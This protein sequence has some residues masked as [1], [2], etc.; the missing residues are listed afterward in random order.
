MNNCF[1]TL[2]NGYQIPALGF[3]TFRTREGKE[4][5]DSVICALKAGFRHIDCA[6]VYGNEK[7]VGNALKYSGVERDQLFITGK[8]WNDDKG[9]EQTKAAFYKTLA[10]LQLDYL[11]LYLIHWPVA[12]AS[13][14][15]RESA[16]RESW[17]A[18]EELYHEGK[19]KAIGVS[20]F[21][22][23]H[24]E[25]LM[26]SASVKPMVNQIEIHP[27]VLQ[28][29]TVDFCRQHNILIEAW[30]PFSNGQIFNNEI[31]KELAQKYG[32]SVAQLTLRWL[33]Q[34]QIVPLPKSVTPKRIESNLD[35]FDFF[36]DEEDMKRI[37]SIQDCP[38]S[39]IDPDH[40][41][42]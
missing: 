22:S 1:Y 41:D 24:L 5:E 40:I 13:R 38:G 11:D 36:I 3:G 25:S 39:G 7:S 12:K 30:A 19:I 9:Y 14:E 37:D 34:K 15:N 42:F 29:E 20:N 33:L 31:L 32:K 8:L 35:I 6:A 17:R 27:G 28:Q 23:H 26:K 18:F 4:T 2:S 10:D 16:N 21:L